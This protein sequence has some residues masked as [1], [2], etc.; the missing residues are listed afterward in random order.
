M[1]QAYIAVGSSLGDRHQNI[2]NGVKMLC[3]SSEVNLI[4]TS[5]LHESDVAPMHAQDQETGFVNG[6]VLV[7]TSLLPN[8]LLQRLKQVERELGQ[9][10]SRVSHGLRTLDLEIVLYGEETIERDSLVIPHP[11]IHEREFVLTPLCEAGA[12]GIVHPTLQTTIG[13]LTQEFR[14]AHPLPTTVRTL[15]LP[16]GRSLRFSETLVMGIINATP[17]SFSDGGKYKGDAELAAQS[18]LQME[19]DGASIIDVGGESTRP[20]A[21]EVPVDEELQRTIPVIQRIRERE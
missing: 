1:K 3:N 11:R 8:D 12:S 17:D 5:F 7:E 14:K 15:P 21:I 9:S 4:R 16:R 6:V 18:A 10:F 19:L 20:G 2:T 13:D